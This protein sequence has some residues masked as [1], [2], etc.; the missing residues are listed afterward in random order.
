MKT[1][2]LQGLQAKLPMAFSEGG[3]RH[4]KAS[5]GPDELGMDRGRRP[6]S[7]HE[8]NLLGLGQLQLPFIT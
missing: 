7:P 1:V 6:G 2:I 8:G 3:H 5:S 4:G